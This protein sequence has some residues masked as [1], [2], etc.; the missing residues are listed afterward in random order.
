MI[1]VVSSVLVND[2]NEAKELFAYCEDAVG[3]V[4]VDVIDGKF[5]DNKTIT[6]DQLANVETKLSIDYHLMVVEPV[7][8]V[9][10]CVRGQADRIIGQIEHMGNQSE[11]VKKVQSVYLQVGLGLDLDTP[12][13]QLD[14]TILTNLDVVLVMSVKAGFGGQKFENSVL[15]KI[16]KLDK[17]RKKDATP[18]KIHVDGG[19]NFD[20]INNIVLAGADEV[21]VGRLIFKGDIFENIKKFQEA[22]KNV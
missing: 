5:V 21:S 11:F 4:S 3:R 13:E 8:W 10:K 15:E 14:F 2:I 12:I 22:V 7:N 20:N 6:P 17:I 18:F 16:K 19:V 1:E 9:E